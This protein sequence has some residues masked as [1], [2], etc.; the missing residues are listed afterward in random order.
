M[1]NCMEKACSDCVVLA[2]SLSVNLYITGTDADSVFRTRSNGSSTELYPSTTTERAYTLE[3]ALVVEGG[4]EGAARAGDGLDLVVH[5]QER[6]DEI[7]GGGQQWLELLKRG[8]HDGCAQL[9]STPHTPRE[10]SHRGE[11]VQHLGG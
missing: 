2:G 1:N 9:Q 8:G 7:V 11:L 4:H 6:V 10:N 5:A 3:N